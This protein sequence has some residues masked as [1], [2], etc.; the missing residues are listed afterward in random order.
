[1]R[2]HNA[3]KNVMN[4]EFELGKQFISFG[5]IGG[6][7]A[8]LSLAIYWCCVGMG[9]HYFFANAIG[10]IITVAIS[11]VLNNFFTFR[12]EGQKIEWSMRMLLKAYASYFTTGI[13]INSILLWVWNGVVGINENLSP[14]LNLIVTVPLNFILNKIWV[15]NKQG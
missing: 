12:D 4:K 2:K 14:I 13:L 3:N 10:F 1:M 8:F 9:I 6:L 5:I 15:Y 7:N 11:Y